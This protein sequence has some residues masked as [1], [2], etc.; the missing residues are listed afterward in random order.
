MADR[1]RRES[2]EELFVQNRQKGE[3][4]DIKFVDDDTVYRGIPVIA[5][6][7]VDSG[8]P[9]FE[10]RVISPKERKGVEERLITDIEYARKAG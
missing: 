9:S 10:L 3:I 4:F 7:Q 8:T 2:F 5:S 6:S 1:K